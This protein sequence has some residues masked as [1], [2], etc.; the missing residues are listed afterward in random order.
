MHQSQAKL[1]FWGLTWI[2]TSN[3]PP[4]AFRS[5]MSR[6]YPQ[7]QTSEWKQASTESRRRNL[8]WVYRRESSLSNLPLE[9]IES[10]GICSRYISSS[11]RRG[12][13]SSPKRSKTLRPI[14][15]RYW[16]DKCLRV[17]IRTVLVWLD[18][19]QRGYNDEIP[20]GGA[21]YN[22]STLQNG[23]W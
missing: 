9:R 4:S 12:I 3:K 10:C 2:K 23:I 22:N 11:S 19:R 18:D 21:S 5:K 13:S 6:S 17:P 14:N 1:H 8:Y 15:I 20:K 7:S 16:S